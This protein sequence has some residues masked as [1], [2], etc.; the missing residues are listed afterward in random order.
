MQVFESVAI[1]SSLKSR[2]DNGQFPALGQAVASNK[3]TNEG[4][5]KLTQPANPVNPANPA[6]HGNPA[7]PTQPN[8]PKKKEKKKSVILFS[9]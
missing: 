3:K 2:M 7:N 5:A 8:P 4:W 1:K 9:F 6:N